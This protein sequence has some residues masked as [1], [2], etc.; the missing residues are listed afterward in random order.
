MRC[1]VCLTQLT[2]KTLVY[3]TNRWYMSHLPLDVGSLWPDADDS[4]STDLCPVGH[5]AYWVDTLAQMSLPYAFLDIAD[6][7][8][9]GAKRIVDLVGIG[10]LPHVT[11]S[12]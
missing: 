8:Y 1:P 7:Q 5:I 3:P 2:Q 6:N 11:D 4:D 12:D 9:L 10:G